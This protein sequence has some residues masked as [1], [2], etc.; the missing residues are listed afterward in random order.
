MLL[1][2]PSYE[3]FDHLLAKIKE[4]LAEIEEKLERPSDKIVEYCDRLRNQIDIRTEVLI[5]KLNSCRESLLGEIKTYEQKCLKN[6]S[7]TAETRKTQFEKSLKDIGHKLTDHHKYL[8]QAR[9]DEVAVK[10]MFSE[11]KINEFNLTNYSKLVDSK[12]FG[13][14]LIRFECNA[15]ESVD[16]LMRECLGRLSYE[17][18]K[19]SDEKILNPDKL[20]QIRPEKTIECRMAVDLVKELDSKYIVSSENCVKIFENDSPEATAEIR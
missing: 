2:C 17:E 8:N 1:R 18:L 15:V 11:A 16:V 19:L 10:K 4:E 20:T 3:K 9:I 7:I 5:E 14:S 12:L 6:N 13:A